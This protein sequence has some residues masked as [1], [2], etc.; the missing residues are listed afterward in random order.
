LVSDAG[1]NGIFIYDYFG[2]FLNYITGKTIKQAAGLAVDDKNRIYL[3]DLEGAAIYIFTTAGKLLEKIDRIGGQLL[4]KPQDVA[5]YRNKPDDYV[6]YL[7]DG[8]F[9]KIASLKYAQ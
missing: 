3:T 6:I 7:I 4:K 9:I 2:N 5:L 8:N 1:R